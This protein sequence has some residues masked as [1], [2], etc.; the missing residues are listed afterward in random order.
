MGLCVFKTLLNLSCMTS[1]IDDVTMVHLKC[2]FGRL[3]WDFNSYSGIGRLAVG[4]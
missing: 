3:F 1:L 4:T 2:A